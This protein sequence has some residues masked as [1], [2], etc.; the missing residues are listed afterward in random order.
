MPTVKESI[1]II[2]KILKLKP[3]IQYSGGK[4]G[5]VNNLHLFRYL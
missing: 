5:W 1:E 2:C 4:R 3:K